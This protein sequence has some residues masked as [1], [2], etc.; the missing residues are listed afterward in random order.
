M[1][2]VDDHPKV[3]NS[4]HRK[5]RCLM[6]RSCRVAIVAT[7][8]CCCSI[9][10][11]QLPQLLLKLEGLENG[12][13]A[14]SM[15]CFDA[16]GK[17]LKQIS[18]YGLSPKSSAYGWRKVRGKFGPGTRK[19]LPDGAQSICIR[20]SFYE[21]DG[22]CRGRLTVDNVVLLPYEPPVHEG[23]PAEITADVGD[24]QV[25]FESRSFWTLYRIDYKG[26]RLC[27]DRWGSHYG[28]VVSFPGVGF[29]GSGHTENEDE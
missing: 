17:S 27:M 19:P 28:S 10:T 1:I 23:W 18:F 16:Q 5:R 25:R 8:I 20:F 11:A 26:T 3:R 21:A 15:Y 4:D 9:L 13:F 7:L 6:P 24:L 2:A 14:F 29:I 22:D 12:V